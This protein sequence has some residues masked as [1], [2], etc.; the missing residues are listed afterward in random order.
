MPLSFDFTGGVLVDKVAFKKPNPDKEEVVSAFITIV[1]QVEKDVLAKLLD[2]ATT[3]VLGCWHS[4]IRDNEQSPKHPNKKKTELSNIYSDHY[5][6]LS[7]SQFNGVDLKG[8]SYIHKPHAR[9]ELTLIANVDKPTKIQQNLLIELLQTTCSCRID[10]DPDLFGYDE[11]IPEATEDLAAEVQEELDDMIS[12]L[13]M[14]SVEL[15]EAEIADTVNEEHLVAVEQALV[16]VFTEQEEDAVDET[17]DSSSEDIFGD[18]V[19]LEDVKIFVKSEGKVVRSSIQKS[20]RVGYNRAERILEQL[21]R[22]NVISAR[23]D[24][25]KRTVINEGEG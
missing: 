21:E 16:S 2:C 19:F 13:E 23:D 4:W 20:F 10:C 12:D 14:K 1:G 17:V 9:I 8:F 3:E 24:Q 7:D 5:L 25:G 15:E 11:S 18:D 22:D 6:I